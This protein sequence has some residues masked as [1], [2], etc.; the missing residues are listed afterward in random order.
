MSARIGVQRPCEAQ[1]RVGHDTHPRVDEE[2]DFRTRSHIVDVA[3]PGIGTI[4]DR[5]G[6]ERQGH[7]ALRGEGADPGARRLARPVQDDRAGRTTV[8]GACDRLQAARDRVLFVASEKDDA[9]IHQRRKS[10]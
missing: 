1:Q 5:G 9:P 3:V 8:G 7:R 2:V 4:V 10:R 6:V